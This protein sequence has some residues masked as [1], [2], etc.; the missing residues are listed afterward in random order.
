MKS[1]K[2][3]TTART[4]GAMPS[5]PPSPVKAV[6][7]G[8]PRTT[9]TTTL[10]SPAATRI[11]R[12]SRVCRPRSRSIAS[13]SWSSTKS[14][15]RQQHVGFRRAGGVIRP[16]RGVPRLRHAAVPRHDFDGAPLARH[17]L[18]V[19]RFEREVTHGR[20]R[21]EIVAG[22]ATSMWMRAT[23]GL[24]RLRVQAARRRASSGPGPPQRPPS[25]RARVGSAA[26]ARAGRRGPYHRG[27][28]EPGRS[29]GVRAARSTRSSAP[30]CC[31]IASTRGDPQPWRVL[32]RPARGH[33]SAGAAGGGPPFPRT[34]QVGLVRARRRASGSARRAGPRSGRAAHAAHLRPRE[35]KRAPGP[36]RRASF[37]VGACEGYACTLRPRRRAPARRRDRGGGTRPD[38]RGA[39]GSR[40]ADLHPAG[41]PASFCRRRAG[42]NPDGRGRAGAPPRQCDDFGPSSR[43]SAA[44]RSLG[45]SRMP[46]AS[47]DERTAGS[48]R[49]SR[50]PTTRSAGKPVSSRRRRAATRRRPGA[51][52][53]PRLSSVHIEVGGDAHSS[54]SGDRR[55]T[56]VP[57]TPMRR[58]NRELPI[59]PRARR[60]RRRATWT[61]P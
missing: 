61:S 5:C 13:T 53:D 37:V 54:V 32:G 39:V 16:Q 12:R 52:T 33:R 47:F 28:D 41:L 11:A 27:P 49:L 17:P 7:A 50:W 9:A 2:G 8:A 3:S 45:C 36:V 44:C 21:D 19:A 43:A 59:A 25:C 22:K 20:V 34:G 40:S 35:Q 26:V 51:A 6:K 48:A 1:A 24:R 14:T 60:C 10:A 29:V 55:V 23:T 56:L 30:R 38:P 58:R 57:S 31:A 4:H 46:T 42:R 15:V 18:S